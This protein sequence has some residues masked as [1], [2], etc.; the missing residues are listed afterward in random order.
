MIQ[1]ERVLS[2][3]LA[4]IKSN[5]KTIDCKDS[6]GRFKD[7]ARENNDYL[8]D[9]IHGATQNGTMQQTI[10]QIEELIND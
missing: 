7:Y 8:I 4:T 6:S 2:N 9:I 1:A 3:L 5:N 10:E